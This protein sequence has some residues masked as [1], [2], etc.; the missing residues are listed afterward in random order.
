MELTKEKFLLA[1]VVELSESSTF[2]LNLVL[3]CLAITVSDFPSLLVVHGSCLKLEAISSHV[4]IGIHS[5]RVE[6]VQ[7]F[8]KGSH[9]LT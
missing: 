6:I 7:Y 1:L 2:K 5:S 9:Y 8:F 4:Y 3:S